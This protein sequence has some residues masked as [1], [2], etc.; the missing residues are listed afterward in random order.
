MMI[1]PFFDCG[2][3]LVSFGS[4]KNSLLFWWLVVVI[5]HPSTKETKN[6]AILLYAMIVPFHHSLFTI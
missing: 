5:R 6:E 3:R 2:I 4:M 1:P